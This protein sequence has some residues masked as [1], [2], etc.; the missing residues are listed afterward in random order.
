MF[1]CV[2]LC[3]VVLCTFDL[4]RKFCCCFRSV[5]LFTLS[6]IAIISVRSFSC[7]LCLIVLRGGGGKKKR[8]KKTGGR[9]VGRSHTGLSTT[10]C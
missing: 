9:G 7:S 10:Q 2:H 5:C 4:W 3:Y 1:L 8:K 6:V